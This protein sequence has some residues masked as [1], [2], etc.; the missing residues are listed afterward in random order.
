MNHRQK[1]RN[2]DSQI[3]ILIIFLKNGRELKKYS[4]TYLQTGN[5]TILIRPN[6]LS[7]MKKSLIFQFLL[8]NEFRGRKEER[9]H[10]SYGG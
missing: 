8:K 2:R 3:E 10:E 5:P 1:F 9:E 6:K 7:V 4:Q